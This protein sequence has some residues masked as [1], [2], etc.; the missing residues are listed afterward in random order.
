[1]RR[2]DSQGDGKPLNLECP[3]SASLYSVVADDLAAATGGESLECRVR[4]AVLD[5]PD[6]PINKDELT[7][8]GMSAAEVVSEPTA[9]TASTKLS[10][11]TLWQRSAG[12]CI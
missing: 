8:A 12:R 11:R 7:D 4:N 9:R 5:A 1:M 2:A 10:W 6:T 3:L